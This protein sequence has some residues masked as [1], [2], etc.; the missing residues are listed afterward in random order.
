MIKKIF[1]FFKSKNKTGVLV[2]TVS[3]KEYIDKYY[4]T[5]E[6]HVYRRI[7]KYAIRQKGLFY[8]PFFLSLIYTVINIIPPFFGQMAI[9]ITGGKS[10]Q[11]VEKIPFL[12]NFA[13]TDIKTAIG[14]FF[15]SKNILNNELLFQFLI[16]IAVGLVYVILRVGLDYVRSFLFSF[17]SQ[18]INRDVSA[19]ALKSVLGT[20]IGYFKQEREGVVLAR[21]G[22]GGVI[23]GFITGTF[24][25]LITIPLTILLT[26]A[27]LFIL[28]AKLTI[29]CLIAAPL[30]ALGIEQISKMI[31]P[32]VLTAQNMNANM[33]GIMQENVRGVEVIKIFSKEETEIKRYVEYNNEM[34]NYSRKMMLISA[35]SRPLVELIM[36]VAM[37]II[38]TYGGYLV[39]SNQMPFEFLWGFLLYMLNIS[40]PVRDLSSTIVSLQ[41]TKIIAKRVFQVMDLPPEELH[42]EGK[43]EMPLLK[44]SIVFE[45][46]TFSYPKRG[47]EKPF[48][49]GPIDIKIKKGDIIAFVGNSGGGKTTLVNLIPKLFT[50]QK[51]KITF[52]GIDINDIATKSLRGHIGVVA[53][54]NILFY[55]TVLENINYGKQDA[56]KEEIENAVKIAHAKDFIEKLPQGYETPIG[57]RGVMLSGGQR[58][59]IALARA[60]LRKPSILILDEATS[61]LDTE[62]EMHVQ[63]ALNDI[64][65]LQTTFVIA[66]RL[67]TIKNATKICVVE[68]GKIIEYGSHDELMSK[69]GK[70]KYLYSLQF[71][72]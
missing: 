59:R 17:C 68:N 54:E 19:D 1:A 33:G 46:V 15:Q 51:G 56:T 5:D 14:G 55:G 12:K 26:L 40:A 57:P 8:F 64:V 22:E 52:D 21:I 30:L 67:S 32:R 18:N 65:H 2:N 31:R 49:L 61:A 7:F 63:K 60:V 50:P 13:Q 70:Y 71:R 42:D 29:V 47:D 24:P 41:S 44:D 4:S 35:L 23:S 43:I 72:N 48:E 45:N 16:L 3:N 20:D 69:D 58:Q 39:F 34:I 11:L 62:S 28:N 6:K 66:H 9:A 27:V 38:L 25:S 53:Q 36:I 37:L 10:A